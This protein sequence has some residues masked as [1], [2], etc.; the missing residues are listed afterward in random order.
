MAAA[1]AKLSGAMDGVW[2]EDGTFEPAKGAKAKLKGKGKGLKGKGG[3]FGKGAAKGEE[4]DAKKPRIEEP[5]P[6]ESEEDVFDFEG[7]W[8]DKQICLVHLKTAALNGKTGRVKEHLGVEEVLVDGKKKK[9]RRFLVSLDDGSGDKSIKLEN[10]F[11][12]MTGALVKLR[13][14]DAVELN[15][16][17][18]ECG[19]LDVETMRYDVTLSDGRHVKV[20]PANV[21]FVAR[22]EAT[23][24]SGD[25][26]QAE[27]IRVANGVKDR[28]TVIEESQYPP[29]LVLPATVLEEYAKKFPKS[30]V[31][32]RTNAANPKGV[33]VLTRGVTSASRVPPGSRVVF[34]SMPRDRTCVGPA[35]ADTRHDELIRLGKFAEWM[36]KR[37][38][39]RPVYFLLP[40]AVAKGPPA[41][42]NAATCAWPLYVALCSEVVALE[43]SRWHAS[44]WARMDALMAVWA[45]RPLYL[46]PEKY[47]PP[48]ELPGAAP[49]ESCDQENANA[50]KDCPLS[51][52]ADEPFTIDRPIAQGSKPSP[53]LDA[54]ARRAEEAEGSGVAKVQR[55][56]LA[57]KRLG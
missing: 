26:G 1:Q 10:L 36:A 46:L 33:Q 49:A 9:I 30:V 21:E 12:V 48:V 31:I 53:L 54:L 17:V 22:Y 2:L 32:G 47:Q 14:L 37:C 44:P 43:S 7:E 38:A 23:Q 41:A 52:K 28:L 29:P 16:S 56:C 57:A 55:P 4:P 6:E 39:P 51:F 13:G 40:G 27:R 11:K 5:P 25:E 3:K 19:K 34:I 24:V 8:K 50:A 35:L 45:R 20:K 42:L 15:D 18:G